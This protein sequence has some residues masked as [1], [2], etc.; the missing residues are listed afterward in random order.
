MNII[1]LRLVRSGLRVAPE[2]CEELLSVKN[3]LLF[4]IH[5]IR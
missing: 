5:A 4:V 3:S 1:G 2:P